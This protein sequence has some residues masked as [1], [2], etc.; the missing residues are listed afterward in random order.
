MPDDA[1]D[2]VRNVTAIMMV[3]RGDEIP[4]SLLPS[5]GTF[6]SGTAAW[7]K[8][9]I[10]ESVAVWNPEL[11]IQCGQCAF[12]CPH[13]VIRAKYFHEDKLAGAPVSFKSAPV[14]ARGYPE[15]RLHCGFM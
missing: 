5:D 2:F 1:P 4:V 8:R 7:E 6:P 12:V 11:C 14:N 9:N 10:S 3:E 15:A 13:S